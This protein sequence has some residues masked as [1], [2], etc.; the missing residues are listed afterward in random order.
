MLVEG[1]SKCLHGAWLLVGFKPRKCLN[2]QIIKKSLVVICLFGTLRGFMLYLLGLVYV[3]H[4]LLIVSSGAAS[5]LEDAQILMTDFLRSQT[6]CLYH[7]SN[8][9]MPRLATAVTMGWEACEAYDVPWRGMS[10]GVS[11]P[12]G[13]CVWRDQ[14]AAGM[15]IYWRTLKMLGVCSLTNQIS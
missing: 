7:R 3:F 2:Y 11:E 1:A 4:Y 15:T 10:E 14:A 6:S 13:L 12:L 9:G 8:Q 5:S